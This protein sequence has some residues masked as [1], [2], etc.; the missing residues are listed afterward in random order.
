MRTVAPP[1]FKYLLVSLDIASPLFRPVT[2]NFTP[3]RGGGQ[4]ANGRVW[5]PGVGGGH[6]C[7]PRG[8]HFSLILPRPPT[9]TRVPHFS[10]PL[11]EVGFASFLSNAS[12]D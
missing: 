5:R 8:A 10:P 7:P 11:R 1:N 2:T 9:L 12:H 4:Y 3:P 6:S